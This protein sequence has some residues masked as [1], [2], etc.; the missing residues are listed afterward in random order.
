MEMNTD[1]FR[2]LCCSKCG[3]FIKIEIHHLSLED[4]NSYREAV[5]LSPLKKKSSL[6]EVNINQIKIKK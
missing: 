3:F 1:E 2:S 4:L 6:S 5:D